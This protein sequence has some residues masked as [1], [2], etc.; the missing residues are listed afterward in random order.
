MRLLRNIFISVLV[1]LTGFSVVSNAK[2]PMPAG[3]EEKEERDSLVYLLSSKSAQT[4]VIDGVD[5]RKVV[6]PARFL[7]NY[8]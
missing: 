2:R 8:T 1:V 7:H 6:G 4:I 5:Y 3:K